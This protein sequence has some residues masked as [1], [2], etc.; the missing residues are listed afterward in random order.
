[1]SF[2]LGVA[3]FGV[4]LG[5][6][7]VVVTTTLTSQQVL[8]IIESTGRPAVLQGMGAQKGRQIISKSLPYLYNLNRNLEAIQHV[9]QECQTNYECMHMM[10]IMTHSFLSCISSWRCLSLESNN[11]N[12][13]PTTLSIYFIF[14]YQNFAKILRT[15]TMSIKCK[16]LEQTQQTFFN[17]N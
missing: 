5:Q 15:E 16:S 13:V 12:R 10:G 14:L 3:S 17:I 7:R 2:S 6:E 9:K 11:C 1:M 8:D 4:D